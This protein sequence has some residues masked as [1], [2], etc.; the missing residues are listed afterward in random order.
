MLAGLL[1][2]S[3]VGLL[4]LFKVNDD[5]RENIWITLLLYAIGVVAGILIELT[6]LVF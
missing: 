5:I 3:G 6:G 4:V 2:G 1:S